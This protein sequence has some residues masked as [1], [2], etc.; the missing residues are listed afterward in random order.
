[1]ARPG[2]CAMLAREMKLRSAVAYSVA[3]VELATSV[4]FGPAG[5]APA[6]AGRSSARPVKR[7]AGGSGLELEVA[8]GGRGAVLDSGGGSLDIEV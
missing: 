2:P 5:A 4:E 7:A 1:M 6:R 8:E 3:L